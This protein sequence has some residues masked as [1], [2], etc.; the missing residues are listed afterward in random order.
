MSLSPANVYTYGSY[1]SISL[2]G[3]NAIAGSNSNKGLWY[4]SD[5]G[6]TWFPS[7]LNFATWDTVAINASTA[8]AGSLNGL[9]LYFSTDNGHNWTQSN[10]T[11]GYFLSVSL[12]GTNAIA[13]E[14]FLGDGIYY[15]DNG[16]QTWTKSNLTTGTF[17]SSVLLSTGQAL[18]GSKETDGV[19]YSTDS[20]Q[21]W[22]KSTSVALTGASV[23]SIALRENGSAIALLGANVLGG[24]LYSTDF[25]VTWNSTNIT[26]GYYSFTTIDGTN[27]LVSSIYGYNFLYSSSVSTGQFDTWTQINTKSIFSCSI[28]G[29]N[30]IAAGYGTDVGIYYSTDGGASFT[31]ATGGTT[32]S[33]LGTTIVGNKAIVG[34]QDAGL[35]V[36]SN[37]G[38][39]FAQSTLTTAPA[40]N[41]AKIQNNNVIAGALNEAQSLWYSTNSGQTWH[42]SNLSVNTIFQ[43]EFSGSNAIACMYG[44]YYSTN[45]GQ[46]W[47][48]SNITSNNYILSLSGTNGVAGS[49]SNFYS[50][51]IYYSTDAG[52]TWTATSITT[53]N[54]GSVFLD[55][56][57]AVASGYTGILY[58]TFGDINGWQQS[59]ITVGSYSKIFMLGS[60]AIASNDLGTGMLYSIN[61]GVTWSNSN[62]TSDSAA[63]TYMSGTN[64]IFSSNSGNG[65]Y[66][67]TD[68]GQTWTPS[69]IT[70]GFFNTI[71]LNGNQALAGT[72]GN[73][74]YYSN[75]GGAT[76]TQSTSYT[77]AT[78]S[79]LAI[80]SSGNTVVVGNQ[81]AS[82]SA[83]FLC[84]SET[85]T[86]L[87]LK[88]NEEIYEN[89]S[90]LEVGD[91]VKIYPDGYKKIAYIHNFEMLND[92][93]KPLNSIWK[94]K[95]SDL[96]LTGGH[97][98]LVNPSDIDEDEK[99]EM[100]KHF[101]MDYFIQDKQQLLACASKDFEMVK[102][103]KLYTLY[104]FALENENAENR[105]G[106][107]V[108]NG[109]LAESASIEYL[110]RHFCP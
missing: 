34:G 110:R 41:I 65:L 38:A 16:G 99:N 29:N 5:S 54:F 90:K 78:I 33:N 47:F 66:Y 25:G 60:N 18:A 104:H 72:N 58:W 11:S 59:N 86:V 7:N 70:T 95:D 1:R 27:A 24:V 26:I 30:A 49:G 89:I 106:V 79:G 46:T 76:W 17:I 93:T 67:S 55:G 61:N 83:T 73:G 6:S 103:S 75:D 71:F 12:S 9:G 4:S 45:S 22:T 105:E 14:Y 109:I 100:R 48:L 31:L 37:G 101:C 8:I 28:S 23:Q 39:N 40:F 91:Q 108:N 50:D 97:S 68:S 10:V 102:D 107:Y 21:T 96:Y 36:S 80:N 81:V 53:G 64:A 56:L 57:N 62:I 35:W 44:I 3:N 94:M 15:S 32:N 87:I 20:G 2:N 88:D 92:N 69:N 84:F 98:V 42:Y 82:Y 85:T 74:V 77:S 13:T 51:G 63:A 19:Y 43:L 52:A